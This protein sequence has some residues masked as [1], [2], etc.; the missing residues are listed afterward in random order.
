V[1]NTT[2]PHTYANKCEKVRKRVR[3]GGGERQREIEGIE[4][5]RNRER[6]IG[7]GRERERK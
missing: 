2:T 6:K 1:S 3:E 7:R 4:K 5:V